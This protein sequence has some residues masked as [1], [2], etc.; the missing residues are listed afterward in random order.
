MLYMYHSPHAQYL[1]IVFFL[2]NVFVLILTL[3]CV[4]HACLLYCIS[5]S[6]YLVC[7]TL[8]GHSCR[9]EL[10]LIIDRKSAAHVLAESV[11]KQEL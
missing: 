2:P 9:S 1:K 3:F 10:L 6:V 7:V 8:C 11:A 4:E 5:V